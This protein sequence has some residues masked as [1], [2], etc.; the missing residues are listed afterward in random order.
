MDESVEVTADMI[1]RALSKTM[2]LHDFRVALWFEVYDGYDRQ[3]RA[4]A[5]EVRVQQVRR[6]SDMSPRHGLIVEMTTGQVFQIAIG[7]VTR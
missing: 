1:E 5:E 2:W 3:K 7:T 4:E 6:I